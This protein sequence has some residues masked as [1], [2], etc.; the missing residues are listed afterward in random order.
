MKKGFLKR[1][2]SVIENSDLILEVID[3]RFPDKTR[4]R[5]IEEHIKRKR[6]DLILVL[7][8]SDLV[9]KNNANKTKRKLQKEFP[10]VF[11]S[12]TEKKGFNKLRKLLLIKSKKKGKV[13]GVIG[14]PNTGKSSIINAL[15][16]KKVRTSITAGFTRGEQIIKAGKFKLIDS[17]G[18]IPFS[19]RNESELAL[20]G[21][22]NPSKLNDPEE[23]A[24][25]LIELLKEKN[26]QEL[27]KLGAE[28][29]NDPEE[30]LERI[31]LKRKKIKKKGIPD[32]NAVSRQL[33]LDFQKGKIKI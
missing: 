33:L 2:H 18:I 17:P 29:L 19:E 30:I 27:I 31:A 3:A 20:I 8:K 11:V 10:C 23:A 7:N 5:E 13:I 1:V 25:K 26:P 4:N 12:S 9:S 22:K 16:G 15:S 21:A 14:Y 24:I 32:V 28:K 6:K